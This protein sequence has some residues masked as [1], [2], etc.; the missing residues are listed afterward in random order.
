MKELN[1]ELIIHLPIQ[2]FAWCCGR[3]QCEKTGRGQERG[4][5]LAHS[6][7]HLFNA[8][9][10]LHHSVSADMET[11]CGQKVKRRA[12]VHNVIHGSNYQPPKKKC[13]TCKKLFHSI[14]LYKWFESSSKS[15]CPLCRNLF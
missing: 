2:L 8:S 12:S 4:V 1:M 6:A 3:V 9:E 5:Q 14:C 11:Q 7:D 10:W 15:T 13:R